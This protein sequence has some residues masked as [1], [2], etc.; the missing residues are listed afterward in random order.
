MNNNAKRCHCYADFD[1]VLLAEVFVY[2]AGAALHM[3]NLSLE[4]I[5]AGGIYD[6]LGGGFA[7]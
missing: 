4:K 1:L 3:A 2:N 5:A 7:R 6:H